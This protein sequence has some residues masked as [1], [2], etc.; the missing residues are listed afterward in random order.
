MRTAIVMIVVA[1]C[2]ELWVRE[3]W[4]GLSLPVSP[5]LPGL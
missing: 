5:I 2:A 4:L 1:L 3:A